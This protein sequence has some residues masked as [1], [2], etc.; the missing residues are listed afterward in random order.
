MINTDDFILECTSDIKR[1][2][3]VDR[4]STVP[5]THKE[6][7]A[8]HSYW[9]ALYSMMIHNR[10]SDYCGFNN[11]SIKSALL[12]EALIHD[13]VEA[14][15]GDIVRLFKYTTPS[16]KKEIDN[17]ECKWSELFSTSITNTGVDAL[18][19]E[20]KR[21]V[22]R[23]IKLADFISLYTYLSREVQRGNSEILPFHSRMINEF[24][25]MADK[26]ND[27]EFGEIES[28]MFLS[29]VKPYRTSYNVGQ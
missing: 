9:V 13:A 19:D 28:C 24:I 3:Y 10:F 14:F 4:Y 2:D 23:V 20:C 8:A 21:Y 18:N 22:K 17:A 27:D 15:T 5:V 7:V 29:M 6:T 12:C 25:L 16:L 26:D 1:L 11:D